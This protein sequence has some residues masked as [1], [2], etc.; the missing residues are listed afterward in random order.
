MTHLI[1][2]K[3][4]ETSGTND[5]IQT[6]KDNKESQELKRYV[7]LTES[8]RVRYYMK[9]SSIP[10]V[11]SKGSLTLS[12]CLDILEDVKERNVTGHSARDL[13]ISVFEKTTP[14]NQE[15]LRNL[16]DSDLRC[17]IGYKAINKVW[18]NLIQYPEVQLASTDIQGITFPA[19]SQLKADGVRVVYTDGVFQ[20]RNG[21]IPETLGVFDYLK[22]LNIRLDGEFVCY[23]G[24][25]PL[26]RK[27]SNGII[28]K[29]LKGTITQ[30]E[31][32][33]IVYLVWDMPSE[34]PYKDRFEELKHFLIEELPTN[35][36]LIES[37]IVQDID[38]A[39]EHFKEKRKEGLEGT[40]LKNLDSKFEN[41]R[42]KSIVKMKAEYEADLKV[43]GFEYG[44]GKNSNRVGNLL[45][46][47]ACGN[48]KVSC[49][50]F[51]DFPEEIRDEWLEDLPRIV[52]V[53]Y[54]ERIKAKGRE[55][56]SL[57]LPRVISVRSDKDDADTLE[58][59][60][61]D[62]KGAL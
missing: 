46:E 2:Q 40:I 44:T 52:T 13:I 35:M 39:Q 23:E 32:N 14:Q 36:E 55:T 53:R 12:E 20:T 60:T 25:E 21:T 41:K 29:A 22:E 62:E 28:N 54:N 30:E 26:D 61:Q 57:F 47:S 56:E 4:K 16:L 9:S 8:P 5:K 45:L 10:D 51:K 50:I 17:G 7:Y 33:K 37:I 6:L 27:T 1:I 11:H 18:D 43:T 58:K 19:F 3:L 48:V 42:S 24:T 38:E 31:A 59:M 34:K 15:L 49:G